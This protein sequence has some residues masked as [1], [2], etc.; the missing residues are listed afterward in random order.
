M[1]NTHGV[2]PIWEAA[3][4]ALGGE[5]YRATHNVYQ[6]GLEPIANTGSSFVLPEHFALRAYD[7]SWD[8]DDEADYDPEPNFEWRDVKIW[9][10]KYCG[11]GMYANKELTPQEASDM[12]I[13]CLKSVRDW[14]E[15]QEK[16]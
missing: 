1:E 8:S 12:L 15:E 5:V 4:R 13:E 16:A 9:W 2:P 10:Y 3:I 11:R 7:W 14:E 6:C